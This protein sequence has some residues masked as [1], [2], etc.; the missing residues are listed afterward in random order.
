MAGYLEKKSEFI[1]TGLIG[2]H[3]KLLFS[4]NIRYIVFS[5]AGVLMKV[6]N[7]I[8]FYWHTQVSDPGIFL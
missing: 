6:C 4:K 7:P 2:H 3:V 1:Q 5:S 8:F